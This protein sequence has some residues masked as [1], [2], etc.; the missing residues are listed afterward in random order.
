MR[1]PNE[2]FSLETMLQRIWPAESETSPDG[3]RVHISN[4][5][6]KIGSAGKAFYIE[7]VHRVGYKF[8]PQ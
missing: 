5:R 1:H 6:S 8:V 3:L 4:I 2:V 7:T